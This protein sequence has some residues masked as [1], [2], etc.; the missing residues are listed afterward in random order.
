MAKRRPGG[1]LEEAPAELWEVPSQL[2]WGLPC[3]AAETTQLC[4]PSSTKNHAWLLPLCGT[5]PRDQEWGL[6]ASSAPHDAPQEAKFVTP[7]IKGAPW[8]GP[9]PFLFLEMPAQ[10]WLA[11]T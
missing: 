8:S 1:W 9:G 4:G 2:M 5:E 3:W 6:L 7:P 11:R 10:P